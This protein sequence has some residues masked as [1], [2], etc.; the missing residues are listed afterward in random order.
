MLKQ[1]FLCH[2]RCEQLGITHLLHITLVM[3][4]MDEIIQLNG[5]NC[6]QI[7]MKPFCGYIHFFHV[8]CCHACDDKPWR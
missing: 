7:L 4:F 6:P 2:E 5:A 3:K 8:P 1:A